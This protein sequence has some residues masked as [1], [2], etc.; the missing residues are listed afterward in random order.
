MVGARFALTPAAATRLRTA[1]KLKR[2]PSTAA[3]GKL[4]VSVADLA[5]PT[6]VAL[7]APGPSA[8]AATPAPTATATATASPTPTATPTATPR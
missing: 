1:L 6:P 8:P 7:P 3:L 5:P 4:T 2:T